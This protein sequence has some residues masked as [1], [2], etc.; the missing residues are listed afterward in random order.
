MGI[1]SGT[2]FGVP[3]LDVDIPFVNRLK[4]IMF[5]PDGLYSAFYVSLI[6]G[7]FQILFGMCLKIINQT[8]MTGFASALPTIG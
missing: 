5:K 3:L 4:G 2:F 1:V 6:I 8:K 7:V